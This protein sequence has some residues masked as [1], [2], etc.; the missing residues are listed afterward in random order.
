MRQSRPIFLYD[1]DCGPCARF[2]EIAS[3][4]DASHAVDF[5]SIGEAV[6]SGLLDFVPPSSWFSSSRMIQPDGTIASGGDSIVALL[7]RLPAGKLPSLAINRLPFGP[8]LTS[9]LYGVASRLHGNSCGAPSAL[10]RRAS[11]VSLTWSSR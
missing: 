7:S 4:L 9:R 11:D 5:V 1:A 8:A 6:S 3:F 2:K 10:G